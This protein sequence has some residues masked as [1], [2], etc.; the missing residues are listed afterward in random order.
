MC[1]CRGAWGVSLCV[2]MCVRIMATAQALKLLVYDA[3]FSVY[4]ALSY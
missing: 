1:V 3:F 2:C 4:E